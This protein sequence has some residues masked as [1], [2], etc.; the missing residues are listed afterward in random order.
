MQSAKKNF[1]RQVQ[2]CFTLLEQNESAGVLELTIAQKFNSDT[3]SP[4][5]VM[6][7][8]RNMNNWLRSSYDTDSTAL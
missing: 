4:V 3:V 6:T 8:K 2:T 5:F 1:Y 7:A